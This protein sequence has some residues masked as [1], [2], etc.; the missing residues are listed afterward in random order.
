M[1]NFE[2][3]IYEQLFAQKVD[4]FT[5]SINNVVVNS[6]TEKNSS[7]IEDVT[8]TNIDEFLDAQEEDQPSSKIQPTK[9]LSKK[10]KKVIAL[11]TTFLFLL[12][13]AITYYL[14]TSTSDNDQI[15]LYKVNSETGKRINN[16]KYFIDSD[17][18]GFIVT[19]KTNNIQST[20]DEFIKNFDQSEMNLDV[21]TIPY[22]NL[23]S[24]D[25]KQQF[26]QNQ[27][28]IGNWLK[29]IDEIHFQE[30]TNI[31]EFNNAKNK[32]TTSEQNS[33][34]IGFY[35]SHGV[36]D[37]VVEANK[38]YK[39]NKDVFDTIG[40]ISLSD[41]NLTTVSFEQLSP[42]QYINYESLIQSLKSLTSEKYH[43]QKLISSKNVKIVTESELKEFDQ[44]IE[45]LSI[46]DV[47]EKYS[48]NVNS[49]N[50]ESFAQDFEKLKTELRKITG[51]KKIA[52][53]DLNKGIQD[54]KFV[55]KVK[56]LFTKFD[57]DIDQKYCER[58]IK[59]N[60]E[61]S[62]ISDEQKD[63][64]LERLTTECN[65]I[66]NAHEKRSPQF[67]LDAS[68]V[69]NIVTSRMYQSVDDPRDVISLVQFEN[70]KSAKK[71]LEDYTNRID[72]I[73]DE[74]NADYVAS[75]ILY[76]NSNMV[77][78]I[79]NG[80]NDELTNYFA[81]AQIKDWTYY[82]YYEQLKNK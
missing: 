37:K 40:D 81:Q 57:H 53:N 22:L 51:V 7:N 3:N 70:T 41:K 6:R 34:L 64:K 33:S 48:I 5:R 42:S 73:K 62:N 44:D 4:F 65:D 30:K 49:N 56:E 35:K 43:N 82:D 45:K 29:I 76:N 78:L 19:N 59:T 8:P 9:K 68:G 69:V 58:V 17:K 79:P 60:L 1:N 31:D 52:D 20:L 54:Q 63:K 39:A 55:A 36:F 23:V 72:K 24:D 38:L 71:F 47:S 75:S 61:T 26:Q 18:K 25:L 11:I 27:D 66:A 10:A 46:K 14:Y 32:A 67:S 77:V 16:I 74:K 28:V 50:L 21:N 13:G 2:R 15:V 12:T 80:I